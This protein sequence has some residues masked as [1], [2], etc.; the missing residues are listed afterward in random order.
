MGARRRPQKLGSLGA[1]LPGWVGQLGTWDALR[2]AGPAGAKGL[3]G[4]GSEP[5]L[6]G[7]N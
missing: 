4:K 3:K 6:K 2:A 7:E 1:A 5:D